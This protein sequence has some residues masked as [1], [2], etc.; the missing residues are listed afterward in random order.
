ML[1]AMR[2]LEGL[3]QGRPPGPV[4]WSF[5]RFS[6]AKEGLGLPSSEAKDGYDG[7]LP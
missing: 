4:A 2:W 5:P 1:N 3:P 7:G 6:F